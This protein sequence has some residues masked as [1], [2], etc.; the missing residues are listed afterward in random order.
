VSFLRSADRGDVAVPGRRP[1]PG[2]WALVALA[3][4]SLSLGGCKAF[5]HKEDP[6][7]SPESL[8]QKAATYMKDGAYGPAIKSFEALEA[9]YPFSDPARQSRLDIIYAYY[10]IHDKDA[11]VDAADTFIRENPTHPRI[12]YAYYVKGLVYFERA[13]N[14]LERWFS[15]DLSE[16]P[17]QDTRK[18][19]D[20]FLRVVTQYPNSEYAA[21]A[22]QRMIYLRNRLAEY[23]MHVAKYYVRRGSYVAALD[24]ARYVIETYDG[25][26]SAHDALEVTLECYQKLGM[27]Q[28]ATDTGKLLTANYPNGRSVDSI[29]RKPWW[30]VW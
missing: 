23:E 3:V 27:T 29:G 28:L 2:R 16:R 21:D 17:P 14:F 25:S 7:V 22:R 6:N 9:R 1:Q 8:Y 24:R 30:K 11:T 15:V 20:A 10:K 5:R 26:P 18:S 19:F 13:P 4:L 12:D